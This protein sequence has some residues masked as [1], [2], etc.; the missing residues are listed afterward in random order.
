MYNDLDELKQSVDIIELA[1]TLGLEVR[2]NQARCYNVQA[3]NNGDRKP[4][5]GLDVKTNRYKCFTCGVHG[6]V[7]DLYMEV[8]GV[9]LKT[10]IADLGGIKQS[11]GSRRRED[12]GGIK[13]P[14][15]SRRR[16]NLAYVDNHKVYEALRDICPKELPEEYLTYLTGNKR[17]L[18]VEVIKQFGLFGLTDYQKADKSLKEGFSIEALKLAGVVNE[19]GNLI[20]YRHT[21]II[22]FYES[23]QIIYLQG[24]AIDDTN[25][26]YL[27][28]LGIDKPIFNAGILRKLNDSEKVYICEGVF[29][30][31]RLTQ[32]GYN[33]VGLLGVTDF[34]DDDVEM[35]LPFNVVLAL[36]NDDAGKQ[37]ANEIAGKFIKQSKVVMIKQL[38]EGI[39]DVTDYFLYA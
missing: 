24:R 39:K 37:M 2:R 6:S 32:E 3:H 28:L 13:N 29:D 35:F 23:E 11:E 16:D 25:P 8:R 22:P 33:A 31:I 7:L 14:E 38:P 4:S 19:K 5:L 36:D 30:A 15:S 20:F 21:L 17:G 18:S 10:A 34:T 1:R 12:L 27:N 26:K 9:D